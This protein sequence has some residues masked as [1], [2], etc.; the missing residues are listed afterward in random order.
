MDGWLAYGGLSCCCDCNYAARFVPPA[1]DSCAVEFEGRAGLVL[2][3][4]CLD[5][6]KLGI[7]VFKYHEC[8]DELGNHL[9]DSVYALSSFEDGDSPFGVACYS[10]YFCTFPFD[11]AL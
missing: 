6:C 5:A 1:R 9:F 4:G 2:S 8:F 11:H 10:G 7:C 3:S